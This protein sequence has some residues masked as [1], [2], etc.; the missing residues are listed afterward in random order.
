M[1]ILYFWSDSVTPHWLDTLRSLAKEL[2]AEVVIIADRISQIPSRKSIGWGD[3]IYADFRIIQKTAQII[4]ELGKARRGHH[5][6]VNPFNNPLNRALVKNLLASGASFGFQ[7]TR[8]GLMVGTAGRLA[9]WLGYRFMFSKIQ[10]K[11]Q[12]VLCHGEFCRDYFIST[13]AAA[14]NLFV[15]GYFV[16]NSGEPQ[17]L[18]AS[19]DA[20]R[21]RVVYLGQFIERK[22]V[23]PF[24]QEL[25]RLRAD[26]WLECDFVGAGMQKKQ[27]ESLWHKG[28]GRVLP[29]IRY[30]RVIDFLKSY[31]V[32]VLPSLADEWGVVVNEAIM[33]GCAVVV[34]NTCGASDMVR[35]GGCGVVVSNAMECAEAVVRIASHK[36]AL[37]EMRANSAALQKRIGPEQGAAYIASIIRRPGGR[38]LIQPPWAPITSSASSRP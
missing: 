16:P 25:L 19:L 8:P 35:H 2:D 31:H 27:L 28:P 12:Y 30:D 18:P 26:N 1:D 20:G 13:G 24:A 7:Q 17:V 4:E 23:I 22:Q 21:A 15:S 11:A 6:I 10:A 38:D 34:T 36:H 29:P 32:L 9:R 14:D 5:L 3:E 33:A 37:A